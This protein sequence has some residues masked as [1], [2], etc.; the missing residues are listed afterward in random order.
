[1]LKREGSRL[2]GGPSCMGI[3]VPHL[4]CK[5][6][7]IGDAGAWSYLLQNLSARAT[8]CPSTTSSTG[9]GRFVVET[10]IIGSSAMSLESPPLVRFGAFLYLMSVRGAERPSFC[11]ACRPLSRSGEFQY[12]SIWSNYQVP[13]ICNEFFQ[14]ILRLLNSNSKQFSP[15]VVKVM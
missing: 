11:C 8:K 6:S 7:P 15:I 14:C 10:R 2:I 12:H 1:M 9:T 4:K 13:T 3:T 5:S